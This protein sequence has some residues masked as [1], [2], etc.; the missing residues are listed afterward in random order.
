M[1]ACRNAKNYSWIKL[2]SDVYGVLRATMKQATM[3]QAAM[4]ESVL[5]LSAAGTN[6]VRNQI[7]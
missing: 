1:K 2:L 6:K 5:P 7:Q 4:I 3:K